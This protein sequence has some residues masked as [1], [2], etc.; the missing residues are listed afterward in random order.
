MFSLLKWEK[1]AKGQGSG[2]QRTTG[3]GLRQEK[4]SYAARAQT[5]GKRVTIGADPREAVKGNQT[6][7]S[8]KRRGSERGGGI[9]GMPA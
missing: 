8:A 7:P 6:Q 5:Q 3:G 1:K 9:S 4:G 2:A